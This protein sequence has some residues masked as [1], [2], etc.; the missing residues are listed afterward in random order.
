MVVAAAGEEV[1]EDPEGVEGLEEDREVGEDSVEP[2]EEDL[3]VVEAEDDS[4]LLQTMNMSSS[5]IMLGQFVDCWYC[6]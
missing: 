2:E 5:V 4:E 6:H 3:E 1:E